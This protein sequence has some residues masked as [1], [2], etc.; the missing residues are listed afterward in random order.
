MHKKKVEM[1]KRR[2]YVPGWC[3]VIGGLLPVFCYAA[4]VVVDPD[5][6]G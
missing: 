4:I 2:V 6:M 1:D 5:I 3:G